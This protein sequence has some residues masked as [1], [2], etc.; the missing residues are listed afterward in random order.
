MR[1]VLCRLETLCT[2]ILCKNSLGLLFLECLQFLLQLCFYLSQSYLCL[3]FLS[4]LLLQLPH[5]S[6]APLQLT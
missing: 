6:N 2:Y 5:P 1:Q 4:Q 3:F